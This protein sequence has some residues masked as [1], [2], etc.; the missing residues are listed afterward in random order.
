MFLI[1]KWKVLLVMVLVK[2]VRFLILFIIGEEFDDVD[3][4]VLKVYEFVDLFELFKDWFG[5]FMI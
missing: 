3:F 5:I 1:M 4:E 2:I